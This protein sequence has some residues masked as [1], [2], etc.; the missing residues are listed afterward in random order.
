MPTEILPNLFLGDLTDAQAWTG[1]NIS[2]LDI[3]SELLPGNV[4]NIPILAQDED[5]ASH[6]ALESVAYAIDRGLQGDAKVLVSCGQGIERSP[7]AIV[8]F[9]YRYRGYSISNAYALVVEKR[10]Q[11]QRREH[12]IAGG[13]FPVWW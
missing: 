13:E 12:W 5:R 9:L 8:W 11:V 6:R 4:L 10:P 1:L 2:V 7:L 3:R